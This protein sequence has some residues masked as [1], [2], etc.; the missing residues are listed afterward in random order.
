MKEEWK[1]RGA[2]GA[3]CG[4]SP[5][6]VVT[7]KP[8]FRYIDVGDDDTPLPV[9]R[10]MRKAQIQAK[11]R[12]DSQLREQEKAM[13]KQ[14][15][16]NEQPMDAEL[17]GEGTRAGGNGPASDGV[18]PVEELCRALVPLGLADTP[19]GVGHGQDDPVPRVEQPVAE[20]KVKKKR[21]PNNGPM[22]H[23]L[24]HFTARHR[25]QG[26]SYKEALALWKTSDERKAILAG[27]SEAEI[28]R[29]RY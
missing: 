21:K 11:I 27:M 18:E 9:I 6:T 4:S 24:M 25:G 28:K 22:T 20:E 19:G 5:P 13:K 23:A 8:T 26:K 7:P 29:R 2:S 14:A 10:P 17:P 16:K 3:S 1:T 12:L 15:K